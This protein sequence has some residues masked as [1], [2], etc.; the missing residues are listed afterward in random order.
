MKREA[1]KTRKYAPKVRTGCYTCKIRRVKCDESKPDCL[2][3]VKFGIGRC[4]GYPEANVQPRL[5]Q[6]HSTYRHLQPASLDPNVQAHRTYQN[7]QPSLSYQPRSGPKFNDEEEHRCFHLF[8][9]DSIHCLAGAFSNTLWAQIIAQA[10]ENEPFVQEC[11]IAIGALSRAAYSPRSCPGPLRTQSP[12]HEKGNEYYEYALKQYGRA[13]KTMRLALSDQRESLRRALIACL[14]VFCFES[15]VGNQ[16]AAI[17]HAQS[18]ISLLHQ[19]KSKKEMENTQSPAPYTIEDELVQAFTRL[20]LQVS[21]LLDIRPMKFHQT[22]K[23]HCFNTL[24]KMPPSFKNVEEARVWGELLMRWNYHFR[25]ESLAVGKSQEI[26]MKAPLVNWEDS[27]DTPMGATVLHEP[28]EI[29]VA[30]LPE[31]RAHVSGTHQWFLA[32]EPLFASLQTSPSKDLV[33]GTLLQVQAKMSA[34]TLASAFFVLET[35][36][37]VFLPEFHDI[38]TLTDSVSGMVLAGRN[39]QDKRLI[40]HFDGGFIPP[41]FLVATKCRDRALR[42]KAI[43]L[44]DMAP[45]R[46]GV[47]DSVCVAKMAEWIVAVEEEGIDEGEIPDYRRLRIRR[48]NIDL[49]MRR[50]QLQGTQF[51]KADD[52][53]PEWKETV[54][55]W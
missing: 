28:K 50:A 27:M 14:L 15:Y 48:S 32:F 39:H 52:T 40:Y 21:I 4:G 46:E 33:G 53:E 13:L 17:T 20:D 44:L 7:L 6:S 36:Y 55:N 49:P 29:P 30:L 41:L 42:R 8:R 18:G 45:Y 24:Q 25:A 23:T 2:R 11:V 10:S 31:Y 37:D 1:F 51:R 5:V 19:W 3:C 22:I 35:G 43:A 38:V 47:F 12:K 9:N 26:D 16:V 54:L 34:I